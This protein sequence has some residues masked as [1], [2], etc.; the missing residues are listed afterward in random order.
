MK[1]DRLL[2]LLCGLM[3]AVTSSGFAE[4]PPGNPLHGQDLY[5]QH[6]LRCHG[7]RLDGNGPD[8][9]SLRVRPTDFHTYLTLARGAPELEEA[10]RQGQNLTPMHAWDTVLTDQQVYDLVAYIR[11]AVPHIEVKP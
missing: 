10:I 3:I 5:Q 2:V 7:A 6:C 1:A 4:T 8:A 11:S 9:A